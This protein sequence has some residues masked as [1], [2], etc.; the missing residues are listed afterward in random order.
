MRGSARRAIGQGR[1]PSPPPVDAPGGQAT[2]KATLGGVYGE[3]R[4]TP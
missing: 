1:G 3:S 2:G 4:T